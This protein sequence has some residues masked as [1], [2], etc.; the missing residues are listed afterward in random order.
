ME[1]RYALIKNGIVENVI[2]ADADFIAT[3]THQFD[4]CELLD[5]PDEQKVTGVGWGYVDGV[6]I[7]PE[8]APEPAPQASRVL[9]HVGFRRLFTRPEQELADELEV[10]FES[11]PGLTVEQKRTLRTGYKN[12]YSASTVDLD[13]PDIPPML[14]LYAALGIIDAHRPADIIGAQNSTRALS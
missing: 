14:G 2:V 9:T 5:T 4:H 6:F 10:M 8:V 3:I 1:I 11:N 13:D 7:A 12:F